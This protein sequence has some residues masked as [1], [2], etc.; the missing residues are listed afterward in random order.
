MQSSTLDLGLG[1]RLAG[2]NPHLVGFSN[3]SR[4]CKSRGTPGSLLSLACRRHR[5]SRQLFPKGQN[6][7][8]A[9]DSAGAAEDMKGNVCSAIIELWEYELV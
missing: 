3:V 4:K 2:D 7:R 5:D 6:G 9:R 1:V 8:L